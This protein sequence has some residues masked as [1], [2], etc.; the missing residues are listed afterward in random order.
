MTPLTRLLN[1]ALPILTAR[2]PHSPT[3]SLANP[4]VIGPLIHGK[5][6]VLGKRKGIPQLPFLLNSFCTLLALAFSFVA[7][8]PAVAEDEQDPRRS[9]AGSK[10]I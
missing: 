2:R 10:A 6:F 5:L 8:A 7:L 4:Q 1:H 3:R 9:E